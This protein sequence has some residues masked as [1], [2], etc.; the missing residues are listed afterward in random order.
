METKIVSHFYYC[1]RNQKLPQKATRTC[2]CGVGVM[3]GVAEWV[4]KGGDFHR[5][6][7]IISKIIKFASQI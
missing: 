1:S 7:M 5:D 4:G 6:Y 2:V 3:D